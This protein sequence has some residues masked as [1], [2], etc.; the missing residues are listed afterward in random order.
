M[1]HAK[2]ARRSGLAAALIAATLTQAAADPATA[3]APDRIERP[4]P[5]LLAPSPHA[6]PTAARAQCRRLAAIAER[7]GGTFAGHRLRNGVMVDVCAGHV[8]AGGPARPPQTS[9]PWAQSG[10][11]HTP[12]GAEVARFGAWRLHCQPALSAPFCVLAA[13]ASPAGLSAHFV[14]DRV[15]GRETLLWRIVADRA[16]I[17]DAGGVVLTAQ[18]ARRV[19]AFD[20]CGPAECIMEADT[21]R[22]AAVADRLW[23]GAAVRFDLDSTASPT[24]V[25]A[26]PATGFRQG[27]AAL[28]RQRS[29]PR[30]DLAHQP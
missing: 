1:G 15:A 9:W 8:D 30:P 7:L 25:F 29:G 27:L 22:A 4:A 20:I 23:S 14:I 13:A 16:A 19:E 24:G 21:V 10:S 2:A 5:G 26:L 17:G 12:P 11:A 6:P 3:A 28:I 18:S